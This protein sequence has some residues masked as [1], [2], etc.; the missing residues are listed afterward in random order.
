MSLHDQEEIIRSLQQKRFKVLTATHESVNGDGTAVDV[1]FDVSTQVVDTDGSSYES[2]RQLAFPLGVHSDEY[3]LEN[4]TQLEGKNLRLVF[5][6][7]SPMPPKV[8]AACLKATQ[9]L[10]EVMTEADALEWAAEMPCLTSSLKEISALC[11][12]TERNSPTD[13]AVIRRRLGE[14]MLA[15]AKAIEQ[16]KI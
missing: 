2:E 15:L 12:I 7:S 13:P 1:V 11:S 5:E 10:H 4:L 8:E 3:V 14:I 9:L 16:Q 6:G